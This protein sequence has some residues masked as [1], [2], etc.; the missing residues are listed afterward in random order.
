MTAY[1]TAADRKMAL[2][3]GTII[4]VLNSAVKGM[5][6]LTREVVLLNMSLRA[7]RSIILV[8]VPS[9][10]AIFWAALVSLTAICPYLNVMGKIW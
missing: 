9:F 2:R 5:S 10:W 4:G 6:R 7:E 8:V 3:K 1:A